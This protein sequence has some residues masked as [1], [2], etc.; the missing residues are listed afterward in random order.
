[1]LIWR[2]ENIKSL[3]CTGS[4]KSGIMRVVIDRLY[5][6]NQMLS[7]NEIIEEYSQLFPQSLD[8]LRQKRNWKS[9]LYNSIVTVI[10]SQFPHFLDVYNSFRQ[11]GLRVCLVD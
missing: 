8:I 9:I 7:T 10:S 5:S 4:P 2:E 11:N 1:V 3:E 6:P